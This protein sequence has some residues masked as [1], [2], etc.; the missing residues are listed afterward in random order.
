LQ[1][2]VYGEVDLQCHGVSTTSRLQVG[3]KPVLK[4]FLT[5][6]FSSS[7]QASAEHG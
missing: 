7:L 2:A 3:A 1:L 5:R 4:Q 6:L